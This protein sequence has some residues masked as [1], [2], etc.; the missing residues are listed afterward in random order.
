VSVT[1][2]TVYVV[3]YHTNTAHFSVNRNYFTSSGAD[4]A[5]LHALA[6]GVSGANGV[7]RYGAS[8]AFPNQSISSSN[9]W[10]DVVFQPN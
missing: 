5:P 10:V 8:S 1:V 4:N 6:T 2:S 3:S 7:F 9:Y